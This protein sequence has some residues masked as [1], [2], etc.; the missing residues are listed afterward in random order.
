[1]LARSY[2][3]T[4]MFFELCVMLFLLS[5]VAIGTTERSPRVPMSSA[6]CA[7][8]AQVPMLMPEPHIPALVPPELLKRL[9][10]SFNL[11]IAVVSTRN[12]SAIAVLASCAMSA[13]GRG[14]MAVWP[15]ACITSF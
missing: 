11:A 12:T 14:R 6:S 7:L 15:V 9:E 4:M 1:M 8:Q 2:P 5:L 13:D 3:G 10:H